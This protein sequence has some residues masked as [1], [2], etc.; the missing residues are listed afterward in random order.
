MP[1]KKI[2]CDSCGQ[3]M[4]LILTTNHSKKYKC[5]LCDLTKTKFVGEQAKVI[6]QAREER[7]L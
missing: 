3:L 2:T 5:D 1:T 7:K 6:A 4:E